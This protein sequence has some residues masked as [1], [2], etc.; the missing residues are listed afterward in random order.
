MTNTYA[1]GPVRRVTG[2]MSG[3]EV[4][5]SERASYSSEGPS[6]FWLAFRKMMLT[7]LTLGFYRFWM[8]THL[9]R[10]YW[11]AIRIK[12]DPFEYTGRGVEK[13][14]GFLAALI[15]LALYLGTINLGLA[16]AGLFSAND[17]TELQIMLQLSLVAALPLMYFATYRARRYVL[18]RTRWRGIRFGMDQAAWGYTWRACLLMLLTIVTLGLAYPYQHFRLRLMETHR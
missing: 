12:G 6:L 10:H 17:I 5:D 3:G 9:R 1:D 14:L 11:S 2:E 8:T 13:L 7:I 15:I 16:F 4:L 18:A